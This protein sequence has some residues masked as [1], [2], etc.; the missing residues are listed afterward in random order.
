MSEELS[1]SEMFRLSESYGAEVD[2]GNKKKNY[3]NIS[4]VVI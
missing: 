1:F 3:G 2:S 4:N